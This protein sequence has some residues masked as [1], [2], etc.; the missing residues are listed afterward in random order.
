M[1]FHWAR[2]HQIEDFLR[3]SSLACL[4]ECDALMVLQHRHPAG[5]GRVPQQILLVLLPAIAA[6]FGLGAVAIAVTA[7]IAISIL[8]VAFVY[9]A[10]EQPAANAGHGEGRLSA[11]A[12][13]AVASGEY[14]G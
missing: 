14:A 4:T 9:R 5:A 6:A 7:L 13:R 12:V 10:P 3:F 8:L 11:G 1:I 2:H